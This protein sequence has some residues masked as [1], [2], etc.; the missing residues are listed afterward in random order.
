[1]RIKTY[2]VALAATAAAVA[3]PAAAAPQATVTV[4]NATA[5]GTVLLP[6]TLSE[7]QKLDF[8]TVIA[9]TTSAGDVL[10][11]AVTGARTVASPVVGVPTNP[12]QN[13]IFQGAGSPGT[14]VDLSM[15]APA[16]L[17]S[18]SNTLVVNDMSFD[19]AGALTTSRTI[20]LTGAFS[21][22]VGGDFAIAANQP[23]GLY[24]GTYSVTASYQ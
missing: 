21:V 11:D 7:T 8:G 19:N 2:L 12:G 14:V 3:T 18:G 4:N 9:D 17:T 10:I 16:V 13:G 1:M 20:D 15:T 22:G 5:K 24:T 23:N 6:L